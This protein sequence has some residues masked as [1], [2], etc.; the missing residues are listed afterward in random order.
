MDFLS[1]ILLFLLT[2]TTIHFLRFLT[3]IR[4]AN[5]KLPPG[6]PP[7]PIIGNL[8]DLGEKPHKS[9]AKLANIHGPL[10]SLKLGQ[11]TTVVISSANMAKEILRTNDESLSNRTV[12]QAVSV[13]NHENYSLAF[14]SVSPLWRELRKISKT[15]LFAHN[16][17]DASQDLRRS[18][19]Q[20]LLAEIHQS[21]Q[22]GEAVDIATAVFKTTFNLL[23]N[24]IFSF[25][26]FQSTGVARE[27]KDVVTDTLK[28][29]GT[30]NLADFFP[31]LR[32]VDP[33]GIKRRQTKNVKKV[34][35]IIDGLV[36][37]RLK[38][39]EG[40]NYESQNDML[41][42]L[43]NISKENKMIDQTM[44]EHFLYAQPLRVIPVAITK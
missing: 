37:Q 8:F 10:I 32:M 44:I 30:P 39:R 43:L 31:L 20:Q 27:F 16:M 42:A 29:V 7:R 18:K 34:L 33:Q 26:L 38:M 12:L 28:L 13:I 9:F 23:S 41:D 5:Y 35:D 4:K 24:T 36:N 40:T 11:I 14:S 22:V 6:P 21:S 15:Q 2:C 1:C 25:D 17:L 19:V 3:T